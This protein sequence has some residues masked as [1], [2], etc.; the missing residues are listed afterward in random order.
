MTYIISISDL[1]VASVA[2]PLTAISGYEKRWIFDDA[3]CVV[4]GFMVYFFTMC[5]MGALCVVAITRYI[6]ICNPIY[7]RYI[8]QKRYIL[9]WCIGVVSYAL[10]WTATPLV[11]WS[12]YGPEPFGTSCTINWYGETLTDKTYNSLCIVFC[13][14]VPLGILITCYYHVIKTSLSR[15]RRVSNVRGPDIDSVVDEINRRQKLLASRQ[16]TFI[17]LS[18]VITFFI[19]WT[20]YTVITAWNLL[21]KPVSADVQVLPTM[22]AKLNCTINPIIFTGFCERFRDAMYRVR[23]CQTRVRSFDTTSQQETDQRIVRERDIAVMTLDEPASSR[24]ADHVRDSV[25][26][27]SNTNPSAPVSELT[28]VLV[29]GSTERSSVEDKA[30]A[31]VFKNE[32]TGETNVKFSNL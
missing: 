1:S 28:N 7:D 29:L 25:N 26:Y 16:L 3:T 24:R 23:P 5:T 15:S 18:M 19:T 22:F 2:F 12:S 20:P 21:T 13:Y 10:F 6:I 9:F 30:Y 11:G 8:R 27:K 32:D 14:C 17:S 31:V 4:G